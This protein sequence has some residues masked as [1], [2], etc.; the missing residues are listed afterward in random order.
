MSLSKVQGAG[1]ASSL[2]L[3][4]VG[5]LTVALLLIQTGV[6]FWTLH[7]RAQEQ[8]MLIASDRAR[9]AVTLYQVLEQLP[10]EEKALAE[11]KLVYS[12]FTLSIIPANEHPIFTQGQSQ[13]SLLLRRRLRELFSLVYPD[14]P[15]GER[16]L[17]DVEEIGD[18]WSIRPSLDLLGPYGFLPFG[19]KPP[20][21]S[22][23]RPGSRL[24]TRPFPISQIIFSV[25]LW[26]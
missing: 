21:P 14:S 24:T 19:A 26:N 20:F 9:L 12:N 17:T 23:M 3:R 18:R 2:T 15:L 11:K 25:C 8:L 6:F 22:R 4:L 16:I 5:L 7:M 1:R 13:E 10:A